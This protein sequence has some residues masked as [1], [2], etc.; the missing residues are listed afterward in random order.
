MLKF[1]IVFCHGMQT[2][3]W[4]EMSSGVCIYDILLAVAGLSKNEGGFF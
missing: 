2:L 3:L 4:P 1:I